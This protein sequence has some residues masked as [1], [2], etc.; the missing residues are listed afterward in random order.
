MEL[1]DLEIPVRTTGSGLV[2]KDFADLEQA[3]V[4]SAAKA[5]SAIQ[6]L[7]LPPQQVGVAMQKLAAETVAAGDGIAQSAAQAGASVDRVAQATG[8]LGT[9]TTVSVQQA[10]EALQRLGVPANQMD[11]ALKR[12]GV[13]ATTSAQRVVT[14][15]ARATGAIVEQTAAQRANTAAAGAVAPVVARTMG[16]VALDVQK[17]TAAYR[18]GKLPLQEYRIALAAARAEAINLAGSISTLGARETM[19]FNGILRQTTVT[20][21]GMGQGLGSV[22]GGM[23]ALAAQA[24]GAQTA[25][26]SMA[27]SL[28]MFAAGNAIAVG[29]VAGIAAIALA[30]RALTSDS[31]ELAE[32]QDRITAALVKEAEV[33]LPATARAVRDLTAATRELIEQQGKVKRFSDLRDDFGGGGIPDILNPF[34]TIAEKL[35]RNAAKAA[36]QAGTAVNQAQINQQQA[37]VDLYEEEAQKLA[38]T[39]RVRGLD[40]DSRRRALAL[41]RSVTSEAVKASLT[42]PQQNALLAASAALTDELTSADDKRRQGLT[43]LVTARKASAADERELRD[44]LA[45]SKAEL[46]GMDAAYRR[47]S[48]GIERASVLTERITTIEA[49]F[50]K[51]VKATTATQKSAVDAIRDRVA[52]LVEMGQT[53]GATAKTV[54]GLRSAVAALDALQQRANLT[55]AETLV[56]LRARIAATTELARLTAAV[57]PQ[58]A[59][60]FGRE[61]APIAPTREQRR[62]PF[63]GN[64]VFGAEAPEVTG[65]G[66]MTA[67][68]KTLGQTFSEGIALGIESGTDRVTAAVRNVATQIADAAEAR[69]RMIADV[70]AQMGA[71]LTDGLTSALAALVSGG[72]V[73]DVLGLM[74]QQIGTMAISFGL[75]LIGIGALMEKAMA[76][77]ASLNPIAVIAAGAILVGLGAAM[78]GAASKSFGGG[79]GGGG[80]RATSQPVTNVFRVPAVNLTNSARQATPVSVT[81]FGKGKDP[82]FER[83]L[84]QQ[85]AG[86]TARGVT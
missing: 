76:A 11:A 24:L 80:V 39:I 65:F 48:A 50:N 2:K 66:D 61:D 52:L 84:T 18:A 22:R 57:I 36:Q 46:A 51:E 74:L 49:A 16:Q 9:A 56:L 26:G 29:V 45:R 64:Q 10:T 21:K 67:P 86:A 31:R 63:A 27:S 70:A 25:V 75:A 15:T 53:Q 72:S 33:G 23:A 47:T 32:A 19:Q 73:K 14:S 43:R 71:T 17:A 6:R 77:L 35:R 85:V 82:G 41:A 69:A 40:Q 81:Y 13:T 83:W 44:E 8:K 12:M 42:I 58:P 7:A 55:D 4:G 79:A 1:F 68:G 37:L 30:Y 60:T 54:D 34:A 28:L 3:A 62:D 78:R 5:E 20:A 38:E 59:P